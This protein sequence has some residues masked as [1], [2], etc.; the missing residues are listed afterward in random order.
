M[1]RKLFFLFL[2]LV[3]SAGCAQ[4]TVTGD[5]PNV[6]GDTIIDENTTWTGENAICGGNILISSTTQRIDVTFE[7]GTIN[8]T[9]D[10]VAGVNAQ[11]PVNVTLR[12][13]T[14]N[15]GTNQSYFIL[16]NIVANKGTYGSVL[17]LQNVT[18]HKDIDSITETHPTSRALGLYLKSE[19]MNPYKVGYWE[20]TI[21][22]DG[23]TFENLGRAATRHPSGERSRTAVQSGSN[24][25]ALHLADLFYSWGY[26]FT[27]DSY[28]RNLHFSNCELAIFNYYAKNLVDGND[29]NA[30]YYQGIQT[31]ENV[32]ITAPA[33]VLQT[34][35]AYNGAEF[36]GTLVGIQWFGGY[37]GLIDRLTSE[38][39]GK[40]TQMPQ[41]GTTIQN[42]E[43]HGNPAGF[44]S[45]SIFYPDVTTKDSVFYNVLFDITG[46]PNNTR[47]DN[48]EFHSGVVYPI[49]NSNNFTLVNSRF[50]GDGTLTGTAMVWARTFNSLIEN[51]TFQN[52]V[53][54]LA[55]D[56]YGTQINVNSRFINNSIYNITGANMESGTY[57]GNWIKNVYNFTAEN[58]MYGRLAYP[59]YIN[60]ASYAVFK[61]TTI[62]DSTSH[63]LA[64]YNSD[65]V[66]FIDTNISGASPTGLY[67]RGTGNTDIRFINLKCPQGV[68]IESGNNFTPYYYLDVVTQSAGVPVTDASISVTNTVDDDYPAKNVN[69][70][71]TSTYTT[72]ETG[73]T[74]LPSA[75]AS[76]GCILDY[77]QN[78]TER[79]NQTYTLTASKEG[80]TN[81][82]LDNVNPSA[83]WYRSTPG[84]SK[85]TITAIFNESAETHLTG[86]SPSDTLN[87][88]GADDTVEFKIWASEAVD[89]VTWTK[90]GETVASDVL[91]YET[92]VGNNPI[93][94][95]ISG[96]D[97]NGDFSKTWTISTDIPVAAFTAN[98]TDGTAPE[99]IQFTDASTQLPTSWAWDFNG[100]SITD[101]TEQNP[102]YTYETDGNYTVSLAVENE[103]GS[104]TETKAGYIKLTNPY[105]APVVLTSVVAALFFMFA[106]RRW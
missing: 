71:N 30:T 29:L 24:F 2:I 41:P 34:E 27:D 17:T 66:T 74:P 89:S 46:G 4:A 7:D 47:I 70:V 81:V 86:Y 77:I 38:V 9:N 1:I 69:G 19:R 85:H 53:A 50:I 52:S 5:A 88:Y 15:F 62:Y 33:G 55:I 99:T 20:N 90:D 72:D 87:N 82:V 3:L 49:D 93:T 83:S 23:V 103:Y 106:R 105:V 95:E 76:S 94:V 59:L 67:L 100:D 64:V 14:V 39:I 22:L 73:R 101:S 40:A 58:N 28:L 54:G 42:A 36:Y 56:S 26:E 57:T 97:T 25:G 32:S 65:N 37:T 43:I 96:T 84:T 78:S 21:Y 63:G 18:L 10:I 48:C 35:N 12:N 79:V 16:E 104:D 44:K 92:I 75:P 6:S 80:F 8:V 61:N 68:T 31:V 51:N 13:A 91:T 60:N 11:Y 45:L 102:V 98:V